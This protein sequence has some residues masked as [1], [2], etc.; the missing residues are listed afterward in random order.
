MADMAAR[1]NSLVKLTDEARERQ[2]RRTPT[3]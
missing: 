1:T 2:H 3:S